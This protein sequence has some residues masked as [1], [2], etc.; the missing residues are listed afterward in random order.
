MRELR[1]NEF[2]IN[3]WPACVAVVPLAAYKMAA[4]PMTVTEPAWRQ[5]EDFFIVPPGGWLLVGTLLLGVVLAG[6][7]PLWAQG[8]VTA[9]IGLLWIMHPPRGAPSKSV[10]WMLLALALAPLTAYLPGAWLAMPSWRISLEELPVIARSP[11]VTPQPWLTFQMWLLW[12]AGVALAAWCASRDWDHYHRDTLARLYA[13]GMLGITLFAIFGYATGLNPPLWQSTDGFGPFPNR[14]QWGSALGLTGIMAMGILHQSFRHA[15]IRSVIFWGLA[16]ALLTGAIVANGSRGGL[17]VLVVGGFA[18]WTLFALV[19]KQYRYAAIAFSFLLIS[20]ALFAVAGGALLE[21]FVG[22]F[23]EGISE[24]RRLEFYR[25]TLGI[26]RASPFAGFGLGNFQF[27]FPFYLDL[28]AIAETRPVQ[29]EN[30]VV[31]LAS[32]GGWFLVAV[33]GTAFAVVVT[34]GYAKRRSRAATIRCAALACALMTVVNAFFEVSAHRIGTLFPAIFLA[35]LALP[36]VGAGAPLSRWPR[37]ASRSAGTILF[38]IGIIWIVSGLGWK[39]LPPVQ[40]TL[41]LREQAGKLREAGRLAEATV[42]LQ[43]SADLKPLDWDV[44][45]ALA[46][47]HLEAGQPSAAWNE[48]RAVEALLPYMQ[49]VVEQEGHF[50]LPLD[51]ARAVYAWNQALRRGSR[52]KRAEKYG[53]LLRQSDPYPEA[54]S[55]LLRLYQEDP[56]FEFA[57]IRHAGPDGD[58]RIPRLLAMTD[59]LST[60]PDHLV[61]PVLGYMLERS[62]GEELRRVTAESPRLKRLAWRVL[63]RQAAQEK[64]L[65]EALDLHFQHGPKPALP[66]PISRSDLR[67]IERAAAM[68]PMDIATAIAYYQALETARRRDDA[69]WQLRRIMEFPNAPAYIWYLAA[70]TAHE[71]GMHEDA[72]GFLQTYEQK[73]KP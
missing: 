67:S 56:E 52:G 48:F 21:R 53:A 15:H 28:E 24:D 11:F 61:A 54:Q 29:P 47:F 71:R 43:K 13:G 32:E 40:G 73:S 26:V 14:N 5:R 46:A 16:L 31:W 59:N 60:A 37:F 34:L 18:Y 66:A 33:V 22:T 36:A 19:S 50:W 6:G 12:M 3:R 30:S 39:V 35:A 69:F 63:S 17:I 49:S 4:R 9:G 2:D 25:M 72:W 1:H 38:A 8:L 55:L 70:R 51:P 27:T 23:E 68:A 45:W 10:L 7:R 62:R 64:N 65:P 20:F 42:L 58:K 57:R 41:A 44:H